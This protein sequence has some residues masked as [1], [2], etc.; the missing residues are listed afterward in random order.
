[1]LSSPR[2]ARQVFKG[3]RNSPGGKGDRGPCPRAEPAMV[4]QAPPRFGGAVY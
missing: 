4:V 2:R 1:M 3:G